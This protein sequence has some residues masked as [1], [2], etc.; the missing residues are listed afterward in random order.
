MAR[1][2]PTVKARAQLGRLVDEARYRGSTVIIEKN[3]QP[4]AALVPIAVLRKHEEAKLEAVRAIEAFRARLERPMAA[5]E[6]EA[7]ID[8]EVSAVRAAEARRRRSP[9]P[10]GSGSG[11]A[12]QAKSKPIKRRR[13]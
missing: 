6:A 7:L 1:R 11:Q 13:R 4:A 8:R 5:E 3:G 2:I 10:G 9:S 12:P